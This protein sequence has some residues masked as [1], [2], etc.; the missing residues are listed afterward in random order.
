M[1]APR[2]HSRKGRAARAAAEQGSAKAPR[3]RTRTPP[4]TNGVSSLKAHFENLRCGASRSPPPTRAPSISHRLATGSSSSGSESSSTDEGDD[5]E[6]ERRGEVEVALCLWRR[7]AQTATQHEYFLHCETKSTVWFL[8][9]GIDADDVPD[10]VASEPEDETD[11]SSSS[12][13]ESEEELEARPACAAATGPR[14]STASGRT[15]APRPHH[16]LQQAA[17]PREAQSTHTARAGATSAGGARGGADGGASVQMCTVPRLHREPRA[18]PDDF[19]ADVLR[20]LTAGVLHHPQPSR[21]SRSD[22]AARAAEGSGKGSDDGDAPPGLDGPLSLYAPSPA[23]SPAGQHRSGRRLPLD[24][25]WAQWAAAMSYGVVGARDPGA[26]TPPAVLSPVR[27]NHALR[28]LERASGA[29]SEGEFI[30]ILLPVTFH[31]S[32]AHNLTRSP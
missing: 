4:S 16:T 7:V 28:E 6:K 5:G 1:E 27:W 17:P 11:S 10:F 9:D 12:S 32:A 20:S 26:S 14:G 13:G 2:A 29:S 31:A 25:G 19:R 30:L 15:R 8:P 21:S 3:G 22:A 23:A 24:S 18:A